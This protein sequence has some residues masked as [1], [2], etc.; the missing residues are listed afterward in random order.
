MVDF[1][2]QRIDLEHF[3]LMNMRNA[4]LDQN[5]KENLYIDLLRQHT[6]LP[7]DVI[8]LVPELLASQTV[9]LSAFEKAKVACSTKLDFY[10]SVIACLEI[11][12]INKIAIDSP[13]VTLRQSDWFQNG[14]IYKFIKSLR[15]LEDKEIWLETPFSLYLEWLVDIQG[16]SK[17]DSRISDAKLASYIP[18]EKKADTV[19]GYTKSEKQKDLLKDWKNSKY[20][21]PKKLSGF[22]QNL[23]AELNGDAQLLIEIGLSA[24]ILDKLFLELFQGIQDEGDIDCYKAMEQSV[25]RY[26]EYFKHYHAAY[27]KWDKAAV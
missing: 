6:R 27:S 24:I 26:K 1:L 7:E 9:Q 8:N 23:V 2:E 25:T 15:F 22:I 20:P 17:D 18:I 16:T 12:W 19:G 5:A 21:S 3:L 13:E 4:A 10:F 11:G 14:I